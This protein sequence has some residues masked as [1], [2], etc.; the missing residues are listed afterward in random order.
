MWQNPEIVQDIR[1]YDTPDVQDVLRKHH[2]QKDIDRVLRAVDWA[3]AHKER[4]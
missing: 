2:Q 4:A 3:K 1:C